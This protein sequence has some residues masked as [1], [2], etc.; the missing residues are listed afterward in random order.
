MKQFP[1][2]P[3]RVFSEYLKI[4]NIILTSIQ[5]E[6]EVLNQNRQFYNP[7]Q[8]I[9]QI[10]K[11]YKSN[12]LI[13]LISTISLYFRNTFIFY[14]LPIW[15]ISLPLY[16]FANLKIWRSTWL[17]TS[18]LVFE[19]K[20]WTRNLLMANWKGT[21][22]FKIIISFFPFIFGISYIIYSRYQNQVFPYFIHKN[23]PGIYP[24]FPRLK[25]DT[26]QNITSYQL[27]VEP[28]SLNKL[29]PNKNLLLPQEI[30][31]L[32][33]VPKPDSE[34]INIFTQPE[35]RNE[36]LNLST[37]SN[38]NKDSVQA[39]YYQSSLTPAFKLN[40]FIKQLDFYT[41]SFLVKLSSAWLNK[42]KTSICWP[43]PE[44]I[45]FTIFSL[46]YR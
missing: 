13:N 4:Q 21:L 15:I 8:F 28:I 20:V 9:G 7:N 31:N 3:T 34:I 26:F 44:K 40:K 29:L 16:L 22:D 2:R 14:F 37:V 6:V 39:G 5:L 10:E 25:W 33:S 35:N 42:K 18:F 32:P 12:N 19:Y 30:V 11:A 41:D 38:Y 23:L 1:F 43:F 36:V 27:T 46:P 45:F 24:S 17:K